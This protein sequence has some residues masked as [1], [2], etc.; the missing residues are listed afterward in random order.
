M[1]FFF[2]INDTPPKY[3]FKKIKTSNGIYNLINFNNNA[4]VTK[5]ILKSL[6]NYF[7]QIIVDSIYQIFIQ[8]CACFSIELHVQSTSAFLIIMCILIQYVYLNKKEIAILL[9]NQ[10]K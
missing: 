4:T 1:H 2:Y 7:F 3:F 10:D 5:N 6:H 9:D 8:N